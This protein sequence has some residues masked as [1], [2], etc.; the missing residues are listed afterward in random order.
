MIRAIRR[1]AREFVLPV[2]AIIISISALGVSV[3]E[4]SALRGQ[5][6]ASVWPYVEVS[7][8]YSNEGFEVTLTNKGVGPAL[9][10]D[11]KLSH[12][13]QPITFTEQLDE[14]ILQSVGREQAFSFETYMSKQVSN[15]VLTPAESIILFGVPWTEATRRFV[16]IAGENIEVDGCYC[17][18]YDE[19]W[20]MT[21]EATPRSIVQC[22]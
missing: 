7:R 14:L 9:L 16:D 5:Q 12:Q 13:G 18:I 17:S 15:D 4:V 22:E 11:V 6:K 1:S 20:K 3:L 2:F 19:C 21:I 10:K 8:I